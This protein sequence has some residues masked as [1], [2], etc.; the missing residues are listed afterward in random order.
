MPGSMRT[1]WAA[2][3]LALA[4]C[5][6]AAG[7]TRA[8]LTAHGAQRP[9]PFAGRGLASH[10]PPATFAADSSSDHA[11]VAIVVHGLLQ[12]MDDDPITHTV[13]C[14]RHCKGVVTV[15]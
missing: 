5:G 11:H 15:C 1:E 12:G 4:W 10:T 3:A 14:W 7:S 2:L 9:A 8:T 13:S 6:V